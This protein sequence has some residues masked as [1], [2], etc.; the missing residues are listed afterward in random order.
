MSAKLLSVEGLSKDFSV[1]ASGFAAPRRLRAV[2]DVNFD[3]S[4]GETLGCVGES[5][6]GKTTLG[7]M[8]LRLVEPSAGR[9]RFDGRDITRLAEAEMRPLR[10]HL[11]VVFQDPFSSLNPRL[12]VRDIIAEPLQ[13]FGLDRPAIDRRVAEVME[14]V[15]LAPEYASRYPHAFSGGQRQRIG[16]ARALALTPKLIVCDE[17]VSALDVSIQAQILNLLGDIQRQ[18]GLSLLFISHNL[19]VVRH[20]SHRIA[21]M[22]LGRLV[23]L[24]SEEALFERPL[25]PYTTAL[26]GA[27]PEPDPKRRGKRQ[28]LQGE[29]PSPLD[30]PTGCAF[31]TRCPK[32]EPKC[33]ELV[34]EFREVESGRW[35]RCHFPG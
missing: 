20:V 21:V 7:R 4:P 18:F 31:R 34:P 3:L 30:P 5:G 15:G 16:I 24:A 27:V 29:M 14:I 32:A 2:E 19:A 9:I 17:A 22:Y 12:R 33:R 6:C 10:R 23:E 35:V 26:I 13:N 28:I 25:H 8:I 11:Q 1:A